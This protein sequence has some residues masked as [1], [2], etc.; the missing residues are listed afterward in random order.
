MKPLRTLCKRVLQFVTALK[1]PVEKII[2]G[3][4]AQRITLNR[5]TEAKAMNYPNVLSIIIRSFARRDLNLVSVH[6]DFSNRVFISDVQLTSPGL[7]IGPA[8]PVSP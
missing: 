7:N 6:D 4:V 2:R 3:T 8:R 1:I 5:P